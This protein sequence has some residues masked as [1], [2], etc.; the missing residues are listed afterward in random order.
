[1]RASAVA[2]S[3]YYGGNGGGTSGSTRS[4]FVPPPIAIAHHLL[5]EWAA[6]DGPWFPA[7]QQRQGGP[8]VGPASVSHL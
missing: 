4:F 5:R 1:M 7:L 6:H 2:D 3:P 8:A